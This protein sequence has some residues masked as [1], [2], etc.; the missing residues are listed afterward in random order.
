[1]HNLRRVAA[2]L[3]GEYL[4]P[5]GTPEPEDQEQGNASGANGKTK[6]RKRRDAEP[7]AS[8]GEEW[9]NMSEWEREEGEVE[10][11]EVG[12][13]TNVVQEGG[14]AP[15][16]EDTGRTEVDKGSKKK[17]KKNGEEKLDKNAR[18]KAKKQ[19]NKER[20]AQKEKERAKGSD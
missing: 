9:Q 12:D 18:K 19:R 16:I 3:R 6:Q 4:E 5:E 7:G 14:E 8:D 20:K 17:R 2:G 11:G 13:R 1:M 15:E 10:V